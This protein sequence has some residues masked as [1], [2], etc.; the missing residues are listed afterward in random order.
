M[1]RMVVDADGQQRVLATAPTY[2]IPRDDLRALSPQEQCQ[3]LEKRRHELSYRVLPADQW[4]LFELVVSEIDDC[5]YRLH[6]NLDLLQF[7]VQSFKVMMDDLAQVW[8]GET[9]PPLDITFRDYV[10]A[11]QARRQTTA[12]HDAWDYWQEKLP[13]LPSAPELP[14]VETPPETPHFTTFTSTLEKQEWQAVKQRWQQQGLT[15]SAAL[16]TLFAATLERWSRTTAFTLNLTFFNRQP[17]HPQ[18]NQLIGDFT[19]VTLVDF[20]FS[21]PLT[22]QEQM[23]RTQQRLWQ[24]MAHSEVNGVEAIRELG[25]QRGSQRQPLMPVVFTSM[26]GMTLEGMAI[27]RANKHSTVI[28]VVPLSTKINKKRTL[29]THVFVSAYKS[30]G[31]EQ[32]SIA[33]CEQ[34]TALDSGRI[35]DYRGKVDEDTLAR[36][37]EAVQVQVGVFDKYN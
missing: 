31:L 36:I 3:A 26:L 27:D 12:W 16:L 30:K 32:H 6:M 24:N 19:S 7:D 1:L 9:L 28:T 13:Q 29:P 4:P 20:N 33:L 2:R 25:R 15:P 10:M 21:T 35:I 34:V 11:E 17:I 23:Q 37:T 22:L 5:R 8:R 18:I 14:V